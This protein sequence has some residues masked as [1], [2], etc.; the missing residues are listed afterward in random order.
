MGYVCK[1]FPIVL[2]DEEEGNERR[3]LEEKIGC[4][5]GYFVER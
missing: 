2:Y 1:G 5:F 3:V 4:C